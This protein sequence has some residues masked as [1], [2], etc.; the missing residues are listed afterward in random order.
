M[1][2]I[3]GHN[4]KLGEVRKDF[5]QLPRAFRESLALPTVISTLISDF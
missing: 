4:Q 5:P 2:K 1:S 3:A